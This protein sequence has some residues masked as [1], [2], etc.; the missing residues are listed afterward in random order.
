MFILAPGPTI[1]CM[2]SADWRLT[3][4]SSV[5]AP[6]W[7]G[8]YVSYGDAVFVFIDPPTLRKLSKLTA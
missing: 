1:S 7:S 8:A 5:P 3:S 4:A 2:P 6:I